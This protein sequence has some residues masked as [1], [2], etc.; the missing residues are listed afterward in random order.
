[1]NTIVECRPLAPDVKMFRIHSPKIA[2]KQQAGQF[3]IVRVRSDGERIPLTIAESDP[4]VGSITLVVQAV[5]KTTT[6]LN[7]LDVGDEILDLAGPLGT[8]TEV[9]N[10]G[11]VVVVG[12]GV[13]TAVSYPTAA[14][15]SR[16]GNTVIAIIGARSRPQL[17]MESELRAVCDEV[18]ACTDDGSYGRR[19]LVTDA[20]TDLLKSG[21][22]DRVLVAGPVPMMGAVAE[23]TRPYGVATVA[24]LNP[25]MIDGTGMCGGCRVSVGGTN[26]FACLDGPDFDAHLVDFGLLQ[27]RNQAY[28]DSEAR[29]MEDVRPCGA[30]SGSLGVEQTR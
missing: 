21:A 6:L 13:G 30:P 11:T 3:V 15:L 20:L 16:S 7:A 14:A 22:L 5:G 17:L 25:I 2:R 23:L 9:V 19:G 12:G 28:R 18:I 4:E 10:F 8:P 29:S 24:S 27:Q 26:R 1:M